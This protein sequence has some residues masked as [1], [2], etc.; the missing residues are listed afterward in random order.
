MSAPTS[1]AAAPTAHQAKGRIHLTTPPARSWAECAEP[2]AEQLHPDDK[3]QPRQDDRAIVAH[4][5]LEATQQLR[6][7]LTHGEVETHRRAHAQS[8]DDGEHGVGDGLPAA[9][10]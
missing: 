7:P 3:T 6:R 9:A 5:V 10:D 2:V 1:S 8:P 4:P